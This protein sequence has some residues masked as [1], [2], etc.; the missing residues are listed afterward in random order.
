MARRRDISRDEILDA[1]QQLLQTRGCNGFS[2][3]DLGGEVGLRTA[4][5]HYHFP[6]K[7]DLLAAVVSRY[8]DRLNERIA[9]IEA[10]TE[11]LRVRLERVAGLFHPPGQG[12]KICVLGVMAADFPTLSRGPAEEAKALTANLLGW[13]TRFL[14]QAEADGELP[15]G[16]E[17]ETTAAAFL[18]DIQGA[19]LLERTAGPG[20]AERVIHC[21]LIRITGDEKPA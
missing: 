8:R 15:A 21:L 19:L 16:M 13:L 4:S 10:E 7:A 5:L 9:G 2:M 14:L 18:A 12:G 11:L 1:A 20:I 17:P 3:R 6:A